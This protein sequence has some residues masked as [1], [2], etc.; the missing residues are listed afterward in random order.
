MTFGHEIEFICINIRLKKLLTIIAIMKRKVFLATFVTLFSCTFLF[1]QL[2][3]VSGKVL[4]E[5]GV[6]LEKASV[7]L[8]EKGTGVKCDSAGN[9]TIKVPDDGK[10]HEILVS[11]NGYNE[12]KITVAAN[13][14]SVTVNLVRKEASA[15]D[16]IVVIGFQ[17][18]KRK[19]AI[20]TLTTIGAKD[21]ANVPV[22]SAAEAIAGK[23]AGVQVTTS[24]GAPGATTTVKMRG[25]GSITQDASPL[26]VVDGI[27]VENALDKIAPQ[28]IQSM[29][30]LKDASATS[31]YGARGANGVIIIT[32]KSSKGNGKTI[33][34]YNGFVGYREITK[35]LSVMHPLEYAK[36]QYEKAYPNP[37]QAT[38]PAYDPKK[39]NLGYGAATDSSDLKSIFSTLS[40]D[41]AH[42]ITS[43]NDLVSNFHEPNVPFNDWQNIVFGKHPLIQSH[44]IGISG[45]TAITSYNLSFTN[46]NEG[47]IMINS[48]YT[49]SIVSFKLEHKVNDKLKLNFGVRYNDQ[50][51]DGAGTSNDVST[52]FNRLR[53]SIRYKPY[54]PVDQFDASYYDLTNSN[55]LALANPVLLAEQ[56][57]KK[58]TTDNLNL[59]A[60]L[61]Y[62]IN[63]IFSFKSTFGSDN[64]T[65]LT[66]AFN[67]TITPES[68]RYL[69][70][71]PVASITSV[72]RTTYNWSNVLTISG[73]KFKNSRHDVNGIVGQ[74]I[75]VDNY[76]MNAQESDYLPA[77]ITPDKAFANFEQ[78]T[79]RVPSPATY[80]NKSLAS[81]FARANYSYDKKY[82]ATVTFRADGSSLFSPAD[83]SLDG[84]TKQWGYFP[85]LTLA[86]KASS[87]PFMAKLLDKAQITDLKIRATIGNA[88]NNRIDPYLFRSTYSSG[89]YYG[90]N[91]E[92]VSGY[93]PT[94]MANNALIWEKTTSRNIGADI[95]MFKGKIQL[96]VD[97]YKNTTS[98]LLVN[99]PQPVTSGYSQQ[100][101]NVGTIENSG[102]DFQLSAAIIQKTD[103]KWTTNFNIAYNHNEVKN[104]GGSLNA[105][106]FEWN[107]GWGASYNDFI[108]KVGQSLGSIYGFQLQGDGIYHTYDFTDKSF[109]QLKA[110][111]PNDA[112][113]L[114]IKTVPQPGMMKLK[115]QAGDAISKTG[116]DS[117][118]SNSRTII[119][120]SQPKFVGG[121]G[122][123]F[124]YKHWD[125]SIF[126]NFV[127]GNDILNANSVEFTNAMYSQANMLTSMNDRWRIVGDDGVLITD[128][129]T[130]EQFNAG[131]HMYRPATTSNFFATSKN[132][133]D[134]SFL[135]I[136]NLTI[137]YTFSDKQIKKAFARLRLYATCNNLAV[138]THYSGYD[139]EVNTSRK[140]PMT[141]GVD[142]SAYPKSRMYVFGINVTF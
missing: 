1:A 19:D 104:L 87:E 67:D 49:R 103:F 4:D 74:E 8:K 16:D 59:N 108:V 89:A 106:G 26:Y 28:D 71:L 57:Y 105:N 61:T 17:A 86:W 142:Y 18:I 141:P 9:F 30:F 79:I 44:N 73:I 21:I 27:E 120:H 116:N 37:N 41:T 34:S 126:V 64:T 97:G 23:A 137:G 124:N 118:T 42:T 77:G 10:L 65:I 140:T 62:T 22:S 6:G 93:A 119:G 138:I 12:K 36:F 40:F 113:I 123:Q 70:S 78:G 130:L 31:I 75:Y 5:K 99:V 33:I 11:Y 63:K 32:T 76:K 60:A 46:N 88:G 107:G 111:V 52:S 102:I 134:G 14:S 128:S 112:G 68:K 125:V 121:W 100:M 96:V 136:N 83:Q 135:R 91:G 94:S 50:L 72:Y 85:S 98:N 69:K 35:T 109:T 15:G 129:A 55:G 51:I 53:N 117:L 127:I 133:E 66:K 2:K 7:L 115:W 54:G 110:G 3:Q 131:H 48:G 58:A 39:Y 43:W 95:S 20:Q 90:V 80:Y 24:E 25:Q 101:Q 13:S 122:N 92:L 29:D 82:F 38:T 132:V 56:S 47:G 81:F 84:E 114:G 139:P 45:G